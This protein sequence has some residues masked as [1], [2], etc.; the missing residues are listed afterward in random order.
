MLPFLDH[1]LHAKG[2]SFRTWTTN[3]ETEEETEFNK[4]AAQ[5]ICKSFSYGASVKAIKESNTEI[6]S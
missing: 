2:H 6:K 3:V 4:T 1:N 5:I